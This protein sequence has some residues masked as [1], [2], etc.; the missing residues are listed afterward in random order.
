MEDRPQTKFLGG[1]T[2]GAGVQVAINMGIRYTIDPNHSF[3]AG[4]PGA[5]VAG[6]VTSGVSASGVQAKIL[7]NVIAVEAGILVNDIR[8]HKS[9]DQ[10]KGDLKAGVKVGLV[11][12]GVDIVG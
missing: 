10:I 5:A 11:S 1:A 6:A 2:I 7:T 4:V 12:A 9:A 3:F 8:G